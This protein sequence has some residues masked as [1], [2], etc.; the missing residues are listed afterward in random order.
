LIIDSVPA[1][2]ETIDSYILGFDFVDTER[3][4]QASRLYGVGAALDV[5]G[6]RFSSVLVIIVVM[7][8]LLSRKRN[9]WAISLYLIAFVFIA[10]VGN[11]MA[12]T[13]TIGVIIALSYLL[14]TSGILNV[15]LRKGRAKIWL[16]LIGVICVTIP[17]VIYLYSTNQQFYDNIRFGFEGFFSIAETGKWETNSNNILKNMIV[18]PDNWKTWIIGDGYFDN[19]T[20]RDPY[21]VGPPHGGFY[22]NTDIGY[23]RFIFY[24][25]V[26]GLITFV[27][28]FC[29]ITTTCI[30]R[31]PGYSVMFILLLAIN[32]I[33]WLKVSTDIFVVFAIFLCLPSNDSRIYETSI[34]NPLNI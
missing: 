9:M 32:M 34:P 14:L 13:T 18:F 7:L 3:L 20:F 12:R 4:T 16:S 30:E 8:N 22:K 27:I 6:T 23:L 19:P 21:Y 2:K 24:F 1:F 5:A 10:I 11:M 31:F 17:I 29:K 25:G 26:V 28:Y 33:V 15:S